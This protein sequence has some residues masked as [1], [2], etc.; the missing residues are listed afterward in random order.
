MAV[1][2][3][4]FYGYLCSENIL[5]MGIHQRTLKVEIRPI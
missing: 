2:D 4:D 1:Y 5:A 3:A